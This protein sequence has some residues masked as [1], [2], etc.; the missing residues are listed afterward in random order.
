MSE[1]ITRT[2]SPPETKRV[3]YQRNFIK[4]AVC[5]LK[6]PV[7]LDL[8]HSPPAALQKALRKKFPLFESARDFQITDNP[9]PAT[10][11][12]Y[13]MKSK[14]GDWTI[15]LKSDSLA[16]ETS[17]YTDF[18]DFLGQLKFV[19]DKSGPTIDSDFFTRVGLRYVNSIPADPED[20]DSWLN[21]RLTSTVSGGELGTIIH[22][23]HEFRGFTDFGSFS[24]RHG[25][26]LDKIVDSSKTVPYMLDF[27]YYTEN[28][29]A[30]ELEQFLVQSNEINYNFFHWCLGNSALDWLGEG[31][32]K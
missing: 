15:T 18:A 30:S 11:R 29:D 3:R 24:F 19:V 31:T 4:I 5:E 1:T 14:K 8:E 27:D 21:P 9:T 6:F 20:I 26:E 2:L 28:L 17:S 12:H 23:Y 7:V 16:L 13:S 22:E 25:P 32:P 10:R